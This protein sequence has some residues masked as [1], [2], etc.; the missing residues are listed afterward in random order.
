M[1][2]IG[3]SFINTHLQLGEEEDSGGPLNRF[4]GFADDAAQTVETVCVQHPQATPH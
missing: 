1:E 4:N 3:L 2:L